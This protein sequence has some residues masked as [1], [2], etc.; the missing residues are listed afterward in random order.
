MS[1]NY[2][3]CCRCHCL[4]SCIWVLSVSW[5]SPMRISNPPRRVLM[6]FNSRWSEVDYRGWTGG[7]SCNTLGV[8]HA[9]N[10]G[11]AWAQALLIIHEHKHLNF[12]LYVC[13]YH[14]CLSLIASHMLGFTCNQCIKCFMDPRST[15]NMFRMSYG[16][17]FVFMTW[18][19]L[20]SK[21]WL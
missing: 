21:S 3:R 1:M 12:Y 20:T 7:G 17:T 6:L 5:I 19:N 4:V 14:M 2:C 10:I 8:K 16:T 11:I 18:A 9:F 15:F 13:L